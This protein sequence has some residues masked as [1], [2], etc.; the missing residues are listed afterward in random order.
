MYGPAQA[1]AYSFSPMRSASSRVLATPIS[2]SPIAQSTREAAEKL[3]IPLRYELTRMSTSEL[4]ARC[5]AIRRRAAIEA[6]V[7]RVDGEGCQLRRCRGYSNT[8]GRRPQTGVPISQAG[9]DVEAHFEQSGFDQIDINAQVISK[10]KSCSAC[11]IKSC[12]LPKV[13]VSNCC[14][15]FVCVEDLRDA[16]GQ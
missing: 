5:G 1:S 6:I 12:R 9:V 7:L 11:S 10:A 15:K 14:A 16:L 3:S 8:R 13:A 4:L 2:R